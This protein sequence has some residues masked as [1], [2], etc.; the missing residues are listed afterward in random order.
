MREWGGG[1]QYP[2]N[3]QWHN[4]KGVSEERGMCTPRCSNFENLTLNEAV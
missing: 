2:V 4:I 1:G 3:C